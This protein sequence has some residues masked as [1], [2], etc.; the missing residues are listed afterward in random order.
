MIL[1]N[2]QVHTE[3][4]ILKNASVVV[5]DGKIHAVE[6][7]KFFSEDVIEFS[8]NYHLVPGF[9]DLHVHGANGADVMDANVDA[10]KTMSMALVQEGVTSF[11]ATTMTATID[12][13]EKTLCAVRDFMQT[14]NNGAEILGVH[15]EGPFISEKKVGAQSAK[16]LL[17]PNIDYV[18]H[19]QKISNDVIKLITL[20]PELQNCLEFISQ[21]KQKNIVASMGHTNATYVEAIAAI[22]AGCS[23]TT[24]LFNAMRGIHQREP[25]IGLAALMSEKVSVEIIADLV[26]LHPAMM[27]FILKVKNKN[28][29]ALVTDSMR[30]KCL[31][32][33]TYDL[34]GQDVYVENN[35]ARL[36]DGTL[37][38]SILRMPNAIQNILKYTHCDLFHAIKMASE[39][40]AKILGIF[41][42]KGSVT[43]GKDADLVVLDEK[44]DVVMV[45]SKGAVIASAQREAIHLSSS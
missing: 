37:A 39:N 28:Q 30:A 27:D 9:I 6:T 34:G 25:G 23:H 14:K 22:E 18:N 2:L 4:N 21:L 13:I 29:I 11:L 5:R 44:L 7:N 42:R 32:N 41:D 45:V 24:H 26:H 36:K 1:S 16:K 35:S 8:E 17:T 12:D 20:A 40:P 19:W 3:K 43:V 15:L 31:R 33:G 10:L 38:G